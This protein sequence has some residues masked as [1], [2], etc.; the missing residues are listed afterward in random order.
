MPSSVD[1]RLTDRMLANRALVSQEFS[2]RDHHGAAL[3][4]EI[5]YIAEY[6]HGD[7]LAVLADE[8]GEPGTLLTCYE[9]LTTK[10]TGGAIAAAQPIGEKVRDRYRKAL[11]ITG[12]QY[13]E[14]MLVA[15]AASDR[16][17]ADSIGTNWSGSAA[18]WIVC[19]IR[20]RSRPARRCLGHRRRRVGKFQ[21]LASRRHGVKIA[22][23]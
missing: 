11:A 7:M 16:R 6:S 10:I 14:R 12:G 1:L 3:S 15:Y 22:R 17:W 2:G 4:V 23:A 8:P 21:C 20:R 9:S 19:S 13:P 18:G 5:P